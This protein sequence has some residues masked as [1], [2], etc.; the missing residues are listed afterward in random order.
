MLIYFEDG[1]LRADSL[2]KPSERPYVIT[3]GIPV[4]V[5]QGQNS[6]VGVRN[7]QIIAARVP[8]AII[9]VSFDDVC[10]IR[11][12][13][14]HVFERNPKEVTKSP[15]AAEYSHG[16]VRSLRQVVYFVPG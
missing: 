13:K 16:S 7:K 14:R 5:P 1:L 15:V 9:T 2:Y 10:A 11:A 3:K 6:P 12:I 8:A 4:T